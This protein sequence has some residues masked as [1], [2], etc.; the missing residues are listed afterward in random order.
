MAV[1]HERYLG[2]PADVKRIEQAL[3]ELRAAREQTLELVQAGAGFRAEAMAQNDG[4]DRQLSE[5]VQTLVVEVANLA[6]MVTTCSSTPVGAP[7]PA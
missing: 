3:L 2:N 7:V 1:V 5:I 6:S 4:R